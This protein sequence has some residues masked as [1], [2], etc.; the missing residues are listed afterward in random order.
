MRFIMG[1]EK[2]NRKKIA[3]VAANDRNNYGDILLPIL[4]EEYAKQNGLNEIEFSYYSTTNSNMT[5]IGGGITKPINDIPDSAMIIVA[6]GEVLGNDF[7]DTLIY[8]QNN[9]VVVFIL[10]ALKKVCYQFGE[11]ICRKI[12]KSNNYMPWYIIPNNKEQKVI[13]NAVGGTNLQVLTKSQ[14]DHLGKVIKSSSLFSVRDINT[15][16]LI[17]SELGL[18]VQLLPDTAVIMSKLFPRVHLKAFVSQEILKMTER[19]DKYYVLQVNEYEGMTRK[20]ILQEAIK[21]IYNKTKV[22]CFLLPIGRAKGHSDQKPLTKIYLD[23]K[24][25]TTLICNNTIYDTM[26]II[27]GAEC[28]LGTSLHGNITAYSYNVPHSSLTSENHKTA[29]FINTWKTSE[30]CTV[31]SV[32]EIVEFV[33][34]SIEKKNHVPDSTILQNQVINYFN[35]MFNIIFS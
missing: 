1:R 22:K 19:L 26:Y 9:N 18:S 4:I 13:Y 2:M 30:T 14:M 35:E 23:N 5:S 28:F 33:N 11:N 6:G 10:K 3:L 34:N 8:Q 32:E 31:T 16:K 17:E 12:I 29:K 20:P 24:K 7:I 21:E 15:K 25:I 27:S